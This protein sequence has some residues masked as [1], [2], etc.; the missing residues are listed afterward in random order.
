MDLGRYENWWT[1]VTDKRFFLKVY[2]SVGLYLAEKENPSVLDIGTE[3]YNIVCKQLIDNND[4]EYWQL[5]PHREYYENN[6]GFYHCTVQECLEKYPKSESKFDVVMDVG[7]FG[8]N[9]VRLTQEQQSLYIKNVL[10]FLKPKGIYILH[11][12]RVEEDWQYM[13]DYKKTIF[14]FFKEINFMGYNGKEYL[15]CNTSGTEW[16]IWFL[17]KR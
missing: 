10:K 1:Q 3:D 16:D 13:I 6:D 15:K 4:V 11:A 5:E 9:G 14:P 17:E 7:V 12:D 2:Q 8:W